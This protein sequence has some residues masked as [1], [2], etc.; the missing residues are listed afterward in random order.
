MKV[1]SFIWFWLINKKEIGGNFST[2][3]VLLIFITWHFI[4]LMLVCLLRSMVNIQ[5]LYVLSLN[6]TCAILISLLLISMSIL[7]LLSFFLFALTISYNLHLHELKKKCNWLLINITWWQHQN[8]STTKFIWYDLS[9]DRNE[10]TPKYVTK[11][12]LEDYGNLNDEDNL[13]PHPITVSIF[14]SSLLKNECWKWPTPS[15]KTT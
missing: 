2:I 4:S 11:Y 13:V 6:F 1:Y 7:C 15:K 9:I 12:L 3:I 5:L 14:P 8:N 10:T